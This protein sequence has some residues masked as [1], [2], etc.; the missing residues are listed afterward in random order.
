MVKREFVHLI[1]EL[2][3][4]DSGTLDGTERLD[5]INMTSLA[6][7][8]FIALVDEQFGV[9][10]PPRKIADCVTVADLA[11]LLGDRISVGEAV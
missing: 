9:T 1:E 5:E 6:V 8:G 7:I 10:I 4:L 11:A 3:E 2:L